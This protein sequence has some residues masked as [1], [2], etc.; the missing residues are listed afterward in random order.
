MGIFQAGEEKLIVDWLARVTPVH[1]CVTRLPA[2]VVHA[3]GK[4]NH[5]AC[6]D[7]N[8]SKN[9]GYL[10]THIFKNC[11]V[12]ARAEMSISK[13]APQQFKQPSRKGKKAWRKNVDITDVQS[14]LERLREEIIQG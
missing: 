14:G 7:F 10:F 1:L 11:L 6:G 5:G 13:A 2:L 4:K 8:F 9:F 3:Q 12:A